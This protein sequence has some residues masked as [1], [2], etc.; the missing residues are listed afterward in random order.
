MKHLIIYLAFDF[1][2]YVILLR[3]INRIH[4]SLNVVPTIQYKTK[5]SDELITKDNILIGVI[6]YHFLRK[7]DFSVVVQL[8]QPKC[9]KTFQTTHGV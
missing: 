9:H 3:L 2:F 8:L 5:F 1:N 6:K 7:S 4:S